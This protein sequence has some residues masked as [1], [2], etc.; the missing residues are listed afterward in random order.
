MGVFHKGK[1]FFPKGHH[2]LVFIHKDT[3]EKKRSGWI[4]GENL[5]RSFGITIE[6]MLN[7][8]VLKNAKILAGIR[9]LGNKVTKINVMEV[10]D[11]LDWVTAG[12]F[13]LTTAYSIK[14][15]IHVLESLI[16]QL[17]KK[18]LAGMGIKMKRY[19][20]QLPE[21][22][23]KIANALKFPIIEI[24]FEIS[25]T[26]IMMP[27]LTE[28]I[29]RQTH[30]LMKID[31][32]HSKLIHLMLRGGGFQEI[33]E[34]IAAT[35]G[36]AVAIRDMVFDAMVICCSEEKTE[37]IKKILEEENPWRQVRAWRAS[38]KTVA[39]C[40]EDDILGEKITRIHMPIYVDERHFGYLYV[41]EDH[42]KLS[43]IERSAIE[44][45]IPVVA[46]E[47]VKKTSIF[48]IESRHKIEFFDDLLSKDEKKQKRAVERAAFFDF[49]CKKGY[50]VMVIAL[51]NI[52]G[53]IKDTINNS[54]F[55]YQTNSKILQVLERLARSH[56]GKLI[57]GNKSDQMIVLYG[58]DRKKSAEEAKKEII[59][60]AEK[61]IKHLENDLK[62]VCC[63]IGL[64]RYYGETKDLWKSY[65][66]AVKAVQSQGS[67]RG[68][69][70]MH[71]D[72]LG[73]L[74]ILCFEEMEEE[75]IQF[76][77]ETL[78][79]LVLYDREKD[80]E[81]VKT[82]EMYFQCGGNLKRVSEEMYTHYNTIIYRMQRIKE[83][84][85]MDLEVPEMKMNLQVALKILQFLQKEEG[86][87]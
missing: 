61:I 33:A 26:D 27:V 12:E 19:V 10:P 28:I 71:F 76:Y 24:P 79:P 39:L 30:T 85:G 13:L 8:E 45:A 5:H 42:K 86:E 1:I 48:E 43:D 74:R 75:L 15:N 41:W 63:I 23:I 20:D 6:E 80:S 54:N 47:L 32:L 83:I 82:L 17:H 35:V 73:I 66:E 2:G 77:Q 52:K 70:M 87:Y 56:K 18:E 67:H 53:F 29:H 37:E 69:E 11:I 50:G 62:E 58:M 49:D 21:K 84:T 78:H 51:K 65:R 3:K 60:F 57:Y 22:I 46:L 38:Q 59:A 55:L 81:L 14:D 9:G 40:T 72:D 31:E 34:G 68:N 16:P 64:G 36:N 7:L 4:G 44:A 25:H